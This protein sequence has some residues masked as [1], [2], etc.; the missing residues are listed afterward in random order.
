M[1][2]KSTPYA[3]LARHYDAFF[4]GL[5]GPLDAA[6]RHALAAILPGVKTACDLACG[7]GTTA[8]AFAR[9]GIRTYAVDASEE[10]CRI[11]RAKMKQARAPLKVIRADMRS[12]RLPEPVDL[13]TCEGDALNHVPRRS[14]LLPVTKAVARAL[15][16]GGFFYFDV[17]N[18]AGFERYWSGTVWIERPGA[19]LVVRNGHDPREKKAWSN[20]EVLVRQGR[21]WR[22]HS[23]RV[24]EVCWTRDEIEAALRSSGFGTLRAWDASRFFG[25]NAIVR[26]GCR[27][28]FLARKARP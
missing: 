28:L 4:L 1:T 24:D 15:R 6:R 22:R 10:M 14:H 23:D 7:T 9:L 26:P 13:V 5:R 8:L 17:N 20:V 12:F 16:P 21:L 2:M 11:T 27:T 25:A 19:V 18:A 3:S